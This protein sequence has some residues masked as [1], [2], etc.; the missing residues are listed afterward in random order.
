MGSFYIGCKVEN[1]KDQTKSAL[2]PRLLVGSGSEYTWL[3]EEVLKQIGVQPVKKD[4]QIQMANG[5]IITRSVGYAILRVAALETIDEV[6]FARKGD[7][8]LLGARSLEGMNVHVDSR[9]KRIV[10]AGPVVAA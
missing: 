4:M 2:V 10:A 3:P 9:R 5:Q 1:H 8:N 7:L 6:V